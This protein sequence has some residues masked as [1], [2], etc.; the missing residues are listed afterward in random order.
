[1]KNDRDTETQALILGFILAT[2]ITIISIIT[3]GFNT[4]LLFPTHPL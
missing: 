3:F 1:M 2:F 4:D